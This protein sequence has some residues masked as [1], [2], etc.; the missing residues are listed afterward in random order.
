[1]GFMNNKQCVTFDNV[2]KM[3]L[4]NS[5]PGDKSETTH[6]LNAAKAYLQTVYQQFIEL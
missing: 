4:Y 2:G 3:V 1:M 5:K 6:V